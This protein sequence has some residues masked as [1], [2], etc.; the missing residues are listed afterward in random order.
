MHSESINL[1]GYNIKKIVH[2]KLDESHVLLNLNRRYCD[3]F[4]VGET[5][6]FFGVLSL[7]AIDLAICTEFC[8]K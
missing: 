8:A 3:E 1:F 4:E 5:Y 2:K 7:I 6:V